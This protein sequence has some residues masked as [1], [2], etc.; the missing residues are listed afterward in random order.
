MSKIK[1]HPCS[2]EFQEEAKMLGLTGNQLIQKY[3]NEGKLPSPSDVWRKINENTYKNAGCKNTTEYRNKCAQNLGYKDAQDYNNTCYKRLGYKDKAHYVQQWRYDNCIQ[4]PMS[5]NKDCSHYLGTYI[6][7]RKI[8]RII[9]PEMFG[10][11]EKEMPY[12]NPKFDFVVNGGIKVDIKSCCL[13]ESFAW[14]G[15][16][17]HIRCNNITD[18]FTIIAFDNLDDLNIIHIWLIHRDEIIRGEKFW[19]RDTIK[20]TNS[21]IPLLTFKRFDWINK[22]EC[23]KNSGPEV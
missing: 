16:A 11:I 2:K 12:G 9:L 10:G 19:N 20:I 23:L 8:G 4:L 18:Y 7:E 21:R 15:W 1:Y 13:R 17:L 5:E 6:A 22:L 14:E 3:I